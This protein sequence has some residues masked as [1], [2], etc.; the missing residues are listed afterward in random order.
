MAADREQHIHRVWVVVKMVSEA[1][2]LAGHA[3]ELVRPDYDSPDR[4]SPAI[5]FVALVRAGL[6][7]VA[8]FPGEPVVRV[9]APR[10]G[11]DA[12]IASVQHRVVGAPVAPAEADRAVTR[13]RGER[14]ARRPTR[15]HAEHQRFAADGLLADAGEDLPPFC[16]DGGRCDRPSF[17]RQQ[18]EVVRGRH[19]RHHRDRARRRDD[20]HALIDRRVELGARGDRPGEGRARV[21]GRGGGVRREGHGRNDASG[22]LHRDLRSTPDREGLGTR[23][24]RLLHPAG[25]RQ[26]HAVQRRRGGAAPGVAQERRCGRGAVAGR[27]GR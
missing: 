22:D 2:T 5:P 18:V 11:H 24:G 21:P 4:I 10:D 15:L 14:R 23:T 20:R 8:P 12:Q 16:G 13:L 26:R 7:D 6:P 17:L 3:D 19:G 9:E 1:G 27:V 25:L